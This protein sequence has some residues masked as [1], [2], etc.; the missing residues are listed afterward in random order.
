M[1][2][3]T[4]MRLAAAALAGGV[5]VPV[6]AGCYVDVGALQH[7][8]RS[9]PVPGP[10]QAL[11][12]N[13]HVGGVHVTGGASGKVLVTEHLVFR[14]AAPATTHGIS[15]R[16]LTLNSSCPARETCSVSYDITVPR[17]T[18]LRITD[19]VGTIR[20]ASLSGKVI[21]HTN[22]GN[23]ELGSVSGPIEVTGHAGSILGRA[24]SSPRS[25]L[26]LSA[27]RIDVTFSVPPATAS[28]IATAGTVW[29]RV[30]GTVPY[31]IH[32]ST[33][34]GSLR[35]GVTRSAASPHAITARVTT[36]SVIIEPAP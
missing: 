13:A 34:V 2:A 17:A 3:R 7:R 24:V 4:A 11:V 6:L 20:L 1:S 28:A 31:A 21:A 5:A 25:T 22:A 15:A 30:P 14:H 23:I 10:V 35:V 33:S 29:L 19:N 26:R 32:A 16:T 36:G 18:A 12:V 27:G 8:T 9:Y